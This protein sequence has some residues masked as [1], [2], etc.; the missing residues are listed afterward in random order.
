MSVWPVHP[1]SRLLAG[2]YQLDEQL[3][4]G[5][6]IS[7]WQGHDRVL[8][9]RV[10]VKLLH[11]KVAERE[12]RARFQQQAMGAARLSH[13]NIV[14]VYDTG[15]QQDL[16]YL[17]M[18]LVDGEPLGQRLGRDGPLPPAQAAQVAAQVGQALA[19][20]H[21][22]GVV[23]GSLS[24]ATILLAGDG[25]VKVTNFAMSGSDPRT[26]GDAPPQPQASGGPW[27]DRGGWAGVVAPE[28]AASGQPDGRADI[29]ALGGCLYQMLTGRPPPSSRSVPG[30]D[31][32]PMLVSPRAARAGVPRDLD[33]VVCQ[34]MASDPASRYQEAGAMATALAEAAVG[35]D[36][37]AV[38]VA[39]PPVMAPAADGQVTV[40]A[41]FLRQQGRWLGWALAILG[42]VAALGVV[43]LTMGD[44]LS[45]HLSAGGSGIPGQAAPTTGA[46]GAGA[47][48]RLAGAF[49]DDPLGD[50][51]END[52]Q[53]PNAIDHDPA[54][55]WTTQHY[56]RPALG[57]S[58][59]GSGWCWPWTSRWPPTG[60][61]SPC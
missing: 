4:G 42:L 12:A 35:V 41:G 57:A 8:D 3:G 36:S 52:D 18:E 46:G 15:R 47:A 5:R 16:D 13:P 1:T 32:Q 9:R 51:H 33:R 21:R 61:T 20:A 53:A 19:Y 14:A 56:R 55:A 49:A 38:G 30:R 39:P 2:R 40:G 48:L 44:S 58:N 43:G 26:P 31:D 22:V 29:Y 23:H 59:P 37:G 27:L 25:S 45:R 10:L 11:T 24:P 7:V 6:P 17:V 60:W 34:A 54:T 50:G 28:V